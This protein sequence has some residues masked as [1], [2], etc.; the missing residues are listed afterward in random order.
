MARLNSVCSLGLPYPKRRSYPRL[1]RQ[2]YRLLLIGILLVAATQG[3]LFPSTY[4]PI[5]VIAVTMILQSVD[6]YLRETA[7]A[8]ED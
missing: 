8:N 2:D 6:K 3:V 1:L 4:S 5:I 7:I